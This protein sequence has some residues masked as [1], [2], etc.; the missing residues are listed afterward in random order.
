M[1]SNMIRIL[2]LIYEEEI[3]AGSFYN[4]EDKA[5]IE[6]LIDKKLLTID[7]FNVYNVTEIGKI[8]VHTLIDCF[9]LETNI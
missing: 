5:H 8:L 7:K 3:L 1:R 2:M 6:L 9:K 4:G